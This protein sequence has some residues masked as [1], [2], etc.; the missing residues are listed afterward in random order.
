M[1]ASNLKVQKNQ[2][3]QKVLLQRK[4]MTE[5]E[6]AIA[7]KK[8]CEEILLSKEFQQCRQLFLYFPMDLEVDT[9]LLFSKAKD[10]GKIIAYP[11]VLSRTKMFFFE[12]NSFADLKVGNFGVMEPDMISL[13]ECTKETLV[14]VPGIAFDKEGYRIGFGAGYYDRYFSTREP[15]AT[16]GIGYAWQLFTSLP[17]EVHDIPLT[18][19]IIA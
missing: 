4:H 15:L 2:I 3:R 18:R 16:F 12:V 7:S 17:K 11:K 9:T 13:V 14:I 6:R 10:I 19:I 8:I 5:E 1:I